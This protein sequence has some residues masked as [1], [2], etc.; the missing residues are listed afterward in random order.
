M[1][2]GSDGR[3]GKGGRGGEGGEGGKGIEYGS[4]GRD[5]RDELV[6]KMLYFWQASISVPG[7]MFP[8]KMP[9]LICS[10]FLKHLCRQYLAVVLWKLRLDVV[11]FINP[12]AKVSI[13]KLS[14]LN[15]SCALTILI[16]GPTFE[17]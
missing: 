5:L 3:E 13:N 10:W 12:C 11:R 16:S 15:R 2:E 4:G 9:E 6:K 14:Y 7:F 17:L 8:L 1:C